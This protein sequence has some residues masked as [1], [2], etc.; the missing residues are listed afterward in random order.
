MSSRDTTQLTKAQI[1]R[2][3]REKLKSKPD[4]D[5]FYKN[6]GKVI[7]LPLLITICIAG[8]EGMYDLE[9]I[10]RFWP[11]EFAKFEP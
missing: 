1:N 5:D 6:Y 3:I 9:N 4:I 10:I 11:R 8:R 7:L 2:L